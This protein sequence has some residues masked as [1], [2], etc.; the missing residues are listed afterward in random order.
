MKAI[1]IFMI[2]LVLGLF[3]GTPLAVW[4]SGDTFGQRCAQAGLDGLDF[5]RCV[6]DLSHGARP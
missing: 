1:D 3:L 2:A 5:E 6:F 4:V